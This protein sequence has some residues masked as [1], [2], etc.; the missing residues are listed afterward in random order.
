[1][2]GDKKLTPVAGHHHVYA[3]FR[4]L[5]YYVKPFHLLH[6]VAQHLTKTAV[7]Y[8]KLVIKPAEYRIAAIIHPMWKHP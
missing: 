3:A 2:S 6:L 8:I 4:T 1:M 7:R 5:G